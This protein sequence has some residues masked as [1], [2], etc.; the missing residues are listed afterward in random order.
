MAHVFTHTIRYHSHFLT[1]S[2]EGPDIYLP[3][4]FNL[5]SQK[6]AVSE[7]KSNCNYITLSPPT[8]LLTCTPCLSDYQQRDCTP[9]VG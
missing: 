6:S 1:R 4:T 2:A 8:D 9:L 3:A 7:E 5:N